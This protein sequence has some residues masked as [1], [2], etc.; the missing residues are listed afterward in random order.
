MGV[1]HLHLSGSPLHFPQ[2]V[3]VTV[4]VLTLTFISVDRWYAICF[5]LRYVSTNVRAF[6][7]IGF[8]WALALI[9]GKMGA[10]IRLTRG[11]VQAHHCVYLRTI[12]KTPFGGLIGHRRSSAVTQL[13]HRVSPSSLS[14]P[15]SFVLFLR[16][17]H[18]QTFRNLCTLR[19]TGRNCGST[20]NCSRSASSPGS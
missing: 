4:S 2:T 11:R 20:S 19:H 6:G 12:A 13:C 16:G 15:L 1:F 9:S 14:L 3:S 8:I 17:R 10:A 5:P 7:S 18:K